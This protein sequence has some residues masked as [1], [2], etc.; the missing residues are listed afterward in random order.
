MKN[1]KPIVKGLKKPKRKIKAPKLHEKTPVPINY[2]AARALYNT[3]V[4]RAWREYC[5]ERDLFTCQMCGS[6]GIALE[7]HHVK[8]KRVFPELV[9]DRNNGIT[10]CK[11]CHQKIVTGREDKFVYIFTRIIRLNTRRLEIAGG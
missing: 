10:L 11:H 5:F 2:E 7:C 9:L 8:P 3:P 4:Y 6:Q 1:S